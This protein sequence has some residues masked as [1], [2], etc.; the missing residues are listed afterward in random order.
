[1]RPS[2]SRAPP[3]QG[4]GTW[5]KLFGCQWPAAAPRVPVDKLSHTLFMQPANYGPRLETGGWPADVRLG[6]RFRGRWQ[7]GRTSLQGK[8]ISETRKNPSDR[9]CSTVFY[10]DAS[11]AAML[12]KV[13]S[14]AKIKLPARS[15]RQFATYRKGRVG[16]RRISEYSFPIRLAKGFGLGSTPSKKRG[17]THCTRTSSVTRLRRRYILAVELRKGDSSGRRP[18]I[19]LPRWRADSSC[20]GRQQLPL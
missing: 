18:V 13:M 9:A 7:L 16:T 5:V 14:S 1:V 4:R 12:D 2:G 20:V 6:V 8:A 11:I 15:G 3:P 10:L 19:L 17:P